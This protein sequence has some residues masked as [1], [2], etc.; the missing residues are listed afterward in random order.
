MSRLLDRRDEWNRLWAVTVLILLVI[1]AFFFLHRIT[2]VPIEYDLATFP[3]VIGE[4]RGAPMDPRGSLLT[5]EGA[6]NQL[7]RVYRHRTGHTLYL[8]ISYF[9][10]QEQGRE[11]VT[12]S[13]FTR[14]HR[15][16]T[17]LDIPLGTDGS[18]RANRVILR[19]GRDADVVVFWY[20]V[21]GRVLVDRYQTKLWTLWN[22]LKTG[23]TNGAMVA[24][25]APLRQATELD[26]LSD[27]EAEFVRELYPIL[28]R[29][30]PGGDVRSPRTLT[31]RSSSG[32][33]PGA[34]RW[35]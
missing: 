24:I 35:A 2:P 16:K 26:H 31:G 8:S 7:V 20:A 19:N 27:L 22:A 23:H 11:L 15:G 32:S 3:L 12:Y 28:R 18:S 5:V 6:D 21:S 13:S 9:G 10:S 34:K 29:Y 30:F 4:W 25:S 14:L 33:Q 17:P 1:T